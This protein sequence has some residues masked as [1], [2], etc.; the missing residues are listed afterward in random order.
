MTNVKNVKHE[1]KVAVDAKVETVH[2]ELPRR[3]R[4]KDLLTTGPLAG[5][6]SIPGFVT[7][8]I[9]VD[10]IDNPGRYVECCINDDW[11]PVMGPEIDEIKPDGTPETGIVYRSNHGHG[12]LMLVKKPIEFFEEDQLEHYKRNISLVQESLK[13]DPRKMIGSGEIPGPNT[14]GLKI[15]D[16]TLT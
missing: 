3:R 8:L 5:I 10:N 2:T 12:R 16:G 6:K 11:S 15:L 13:T 1:E 4:K 7:Q 14:K 9:V